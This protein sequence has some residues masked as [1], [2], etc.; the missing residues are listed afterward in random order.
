M[1][2]AE[3]SAE[4]ELIVPFHDLDP[5][6]IVWHGN[7]AKYFEQARCVLLDQFGYGYTAMLTSGY[8][9]PVVDLSVRY[10]KPARFGQRIRVTAMLKEWENRL[11]IAYLIH[12]ASTG[13]R[14]TKGFTVQV[15]VDMKTHELCLVSPSI[16]FEKLGVEYSC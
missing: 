3:R 11:K 13:E 8:F 1:N 10:I 5:V 4:L 15:A 6:N 12:D 9:W 7:Y 2:P 16:L 14:L